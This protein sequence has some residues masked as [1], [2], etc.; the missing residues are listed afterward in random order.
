MSPPS[1]GGMTLPG[2]RLTSFIQY[3]GTFRH[4]PFERLYSAVQ[5]LLYEITRSECI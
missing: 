2:A 3:L 1:H 5:Q 4:H